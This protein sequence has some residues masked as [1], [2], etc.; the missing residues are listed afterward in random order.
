M[1]N[2]TRVVVTAAVAASALFVTSSDTAAATPAP[3]VSEQRDPVAAASVAAFDAYRGYVD[4]LAGPPSDPV[5]AAA[6][7][8]AVLEAWATSLEHLAALVSPEH[9]DE[10]AAVW[11]SAGEQ[12]LTVVLSALAQSGSRYRY[13]SS[14]PARGFDCSGLTGFA[15]RQVGVEIPASSSAQRSTLAHVDPA[16]ALPGD[17]V[18]YPGH[19]MLFLGAA[20]MVVHASTRSTPVGVDVIR[21]ADAFL[22][23]VPRLP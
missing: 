2:I 9:A 11:A 17:V 19:V 1:R 13:A 21:R 23:P 16:A 12:R 8:G 5:V 18:W 20:N 6:E 22:S 15:W 10:L 14:D 4:N 3:L 7:A